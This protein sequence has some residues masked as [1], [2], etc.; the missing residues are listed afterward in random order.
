[1]ANATYKRKLPLSYSTID[2][3]RLFV[4]VQYRNKIRLISQHFNQSTLWE[5]KFLRVL[6]RF[7]PSVRVH[8]IAA[9][10]SMSGLGKASLVIKSCPSKF[11]RI[12]TTFGVL[13]Y[14][15]MAY[16][17]FSGQKMTLPH[18]LFCSTCQ[19]ATPRKNL[20]IH[21]EAR[22]PTIH[23]KLKAWFL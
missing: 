18:H 19:K 7:I 21:F 1:M 14:R 20:H 16:R 11:N 12:S 8:K 22:Y 17:A 9:L 3:F 15:A 2:G 4:A 5:K 10:P 23:Q 13:T 6:F